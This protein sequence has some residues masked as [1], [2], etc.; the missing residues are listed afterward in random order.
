MASM[1]FTVEVDH[2]EDDADKEKLAKEMAEY[3]QNQFLYFAV[4]LVEVNNG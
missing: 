4:A 3:L 1:Y 2:L